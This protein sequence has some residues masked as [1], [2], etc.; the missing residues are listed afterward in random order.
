MNSKQHPALAA[1]LF[2]LL[3]LV[4]PIVA[5]QNKA[6]ATSTSPIG[7]WPQW[8]GPNLNGTAIGDAP[9]QFSDTQN[10]KWK[11]AIPG[12]GFSTP[13]IWG[14]KLFLTTAV[15]TGK[16]STGVA[17][18]PGHPNGGVGVNQEHR[19]VVMAIDRKTGKVAWEQTA[20]TATP[21]EGYHNAYGSFASNS[22]V[23]DG[24]HLYAFFGSRGIYCYDLA[25]KLIWKK[26]FGVKLSM[27]NEFG[28]GTAPVV[29]EQALI[30]NFDQERNSFIVVLDKTNGKELW[31]A[32]RDEVSTWAT[33]L[34]LEHAGRKQ[35]VVTATGKV[36]S[37]DFKTGKVIWECAGLGINAIP[38]PV[39]LG[40]VVYVMTGHRD[41]KLM[42]IKLGKEGDLTGTDAILWSHT[43]GTAYT[44]SPVLHDGKFYTLNDNGMVSC[45]DAQTGKPYYQQQR[46]PKPYN[47]KSSPVA[48][49]GKLYLASEDSDVLVLKLGDK[50]EVLAT[51][52]LAD[53]VFI[54]SPIIVDGELYLRSQNQLFCISEN[55]AK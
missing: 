49:N 40:E 32:N 31:R 6:A 4:S 3:F 33:P 43:R 18:T 20:I 37:Y 46:L 24:Q 42:A 5:Q 54:S 38:A 44:P 26:D 52:T 50:F 55:K 34:V 21:H 2:T 9:T 19:F 29:H 1:L 17:R 25:G 30:L 36:R 23:T 28:E 51:N 27:R 15:P 22:P 13:V 47:F 45:F 39:Q 35:I 8:R 41:P 14:D 16:T 11:A 53:Q 12:R 48:A 10:I 7:H